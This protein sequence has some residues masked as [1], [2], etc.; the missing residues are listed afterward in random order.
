[1][2]DRGAA[3]RLA[4]LFRRAAE[5]AFVSASCAPRSLALAR[6]LRLHGL[7]AEVR[8]GLRRAGRELAGHAWVEH[9]GVSVGEDATFASAFTPLAVSR[10]SRHGEVE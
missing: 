8:I 4:E 1:M 3:G 2:G 9:H 6:L 7:A 5:H 10:R